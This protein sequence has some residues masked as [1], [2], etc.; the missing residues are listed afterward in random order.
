MLQIREK[1]I[2]AWLAQQLQ[3]IMWAQKLKPT[4]KF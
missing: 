4:A 2:M 1:S 3:S